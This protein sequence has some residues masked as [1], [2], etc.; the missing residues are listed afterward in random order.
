MQAYQARTTSFKNSKWISFAQFIYLCSFVLNAIN[1][2]GLFLRDS[3]NVMKLLT[4]LMQSLKV[5]GSQS[6]K[7]VSVINNIIIKKWL[8]LLQSQFGTAVG[9]G[10]TE[11]FCRWYRHAL[12][13]L[14]NLFSE[15][16][17]IQRRRSVEVL[18]RWKN[19]KLIHKVKGEEK[20]SAVTRSKMEKTH[21]EQMF[22]RYAR[23]T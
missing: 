20:R 3:G 10:I 5:I 7:H 16:I 12:I 21:T 1:G 11:L 17:S 19:S 8:T 9:F 15:C 13:T 6:G 2:H 14:I 18:N 23:S 22:H 4:K